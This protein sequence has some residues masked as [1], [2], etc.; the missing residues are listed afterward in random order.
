MKL[1]QI[2]NWEVIPQESYLKYGIVESELMKCESA[3]LKFY[4]EQN[5]VITLYNYGTLKNNA[6][7]EIENEIIQNELENRLIDGNPNS[8]G[9]E[10]TSLYSCIFKEKLMIKN[11]ECLSVVSKIL[12]PEG[13]HSFVFQLYVKSNGNLYSI[14]FKFANFNEKNIEKSFSEDQ[15]FSEVLE[16]IC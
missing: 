10:D 2:N 14:Q 9:Y 6:F 12:L 3:F 11:Y 13:N 8:A 5:I 7:E 15:T 16:S 1:R 4:K